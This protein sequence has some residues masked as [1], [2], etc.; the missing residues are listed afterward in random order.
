[1]D[2]VPFIAH[3]A[4]SQSVRDCDAPVIVGVYVRFEWFHRI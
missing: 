4:H 1:M 2:R 3:V